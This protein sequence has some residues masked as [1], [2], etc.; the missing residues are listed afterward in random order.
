[1]YID[2]YLNGG[3]TAAGT[4]T[5]TGLFASKLSN[6]IYCSYGGSVRFSTDK[7]VSFT[8]IQSLVFSKGS[9]CED[10]SGNIYGSVGGKLWKQTAGTGLLVDTLISVQS[11][12]ICIGLANSIYCLTASNVYTLIQGGSTFILFTSLS[13]ALDNVRGITSNLNGILL[14]THG[15]NAAKIQYTLE[16]NSLGAS[17]LDGG[18]YIAKAGTGKGTGKSRYEI[19][20]GQKTTIGT[21][22]QIETLREYVDE[23][24]YHIYVSMPVYA[25]N[26]AATTAGLP[27]GCKYRTSTGLLMIRY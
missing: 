21:D 15:Y 5:V 9:M 12:F 10:S 1:M 14:F 11:Q 20:T 23:N 17:D 26:A 7:G 6:K 24:G 25:D 13:P 3:S 4:N 22:M 18:T 8:I 27:I 2:S 16:T 19:W